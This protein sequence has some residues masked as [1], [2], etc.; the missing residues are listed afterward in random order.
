M[1]RAV[2]VAGKLPAAWRLPHHRPSATCRKSRPLSRTGRQPC[3]SPP[4]CPPVPHRACA[5]RLGPCTQALEQA[6]LDVEMLQLEVASRSTKG[7]S[8][9]SRVATA[10]PGAGP[11]SST[12]GLFNADV[13]F[14]LLPTGA[15][16]LG[17]G[18]LQ[19]RAQQQGA[20]VGVQAQ[21][22]GAEG[23]A[24]DEEAAAELAST[25]ADLYRQQEAV[26]EAQVCAAGRVGCRGVGVHGWG[27]GI[28][29]RLS[30]PEGVLCCV[31]L[32]ADDAA[33]LPPPDVPAG[34][35]P[36]SLAE[37]SHHLREHNPSPTPHHHH[38]THVIMGFCRPGVDAG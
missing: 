16:F 21:A 10:A 25:R 14:R 35:L 28:D 26:R 5:I 9:S 11:G 32:R 12:A 36:L 29:G 33:R 4:C 22:A 3:L 1:T 20:Q 6:R 15:S 18:M 24:T 19:P 13:S 2:V 23:P 38:H 17:G 7:P 8:S 27:A 31:M 37:G 30:T 34:P